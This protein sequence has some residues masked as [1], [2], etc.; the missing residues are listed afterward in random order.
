MVLL[1][2]GTSHTGKTA[3]E[4][5][6]LQETQCVCAWWCPGGISRPTGRISA[7]MPV[8]WSSRERGLEYILIDKDYQV[9]WE[10]KESRELK[11]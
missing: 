4:A 7:G 6:Y 5:E 11:L 1:I 2:A 9:N 3:L 10:P 8:W